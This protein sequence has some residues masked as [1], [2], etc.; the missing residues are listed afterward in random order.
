MERRQLGK[1]G[2]DVSVLCFGCNVFGWTVNQDM[3]FNLLDAFTQHGGNFIDTADTYS[4]WAPGNVGG[5][6]ETIIGNW[7]KRRGNRDKIIIATKVGWRMSDTKKGLSK[8]YILR[9]VEDSLIRLQT[10]YIDLYQAH[11]DDPSVPLEETL[12]AFSILIKQGKVKAI[13]ASNYTAERLRDALYVSEQHHQPLF[14][15]LQP[16]YNL[17]DR[18]DFETHLLPVCENEKLAVIPYYSLA[19]GFLTGKYRTEDDLA[20]GSR[21][22]KVRQYMTPK[23]MRILQ[24]LDIVATR[25]ESTPARVALAWLMSRPTVVAP[26]ASATDLQQLHDLIEATELQLDLDSLNELSRASQD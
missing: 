16:L 19:T 26:I 12:E 21:G 15:T 13:G 9:E 6:S 2:L 25:Y 3:A 5:E 7:I 23:G 18:S 22:D 17:Y 11:K 10:D 4:N 14:A 1:T 20:K 8:A 24:A